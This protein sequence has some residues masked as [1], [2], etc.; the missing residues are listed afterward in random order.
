M[1]PAKRNNSI[2]LRSF[3]LL[4][5]EKPSDEEVLDIVIKLDTQNMYARELGAFFSCLDH[6]YGRLD[7]RGFL[8]YSMT[9]RKQLVINEIRVGSWEVVIENILE[10]YSV[11]S[12]AKF[13][14]LIKYLPSIVKGTTEGLKNISDIYVNYYVALEKRE[15]LKDVR[16]ARK[17]IRENI[18]TD[19]QLKHL[20]KK[21]INRLAEV[22]EKAYR[23]DEKL[24]SQAS[25]FAA[26]KLKEIKI[27]KRKKR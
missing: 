14:L 10:R 17:S 16:K 15:H 25:P 19:D 6:F 8:S 20:E 12:I 1:L 4:L 2:L 21:D 27:I 9:K 5:I 23:K 26:D 7:D 24:V 18:E 11:E 13:F 22:L 3:D